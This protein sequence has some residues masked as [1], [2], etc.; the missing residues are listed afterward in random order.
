M[1]YVGLHSQAKN[2]DQSDPQCDAFQGRERSHNEQR[3]EDHRGAKTDDAARLL[4]R[5]HLLT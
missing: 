1:M 4:S 5:I 2:D 3:E